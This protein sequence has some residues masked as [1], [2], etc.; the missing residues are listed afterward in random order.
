MK[1]SNGFRIIL[2]IMLGVFALDCVGAILLMH[3]WVAALVL[4]AIAFAMF[5]LW[6]RR[7][8]RQVSNEGWNLGPAV[9]L[10][11]PDNPLRIE[12]AIVSPKILNLGMLLIGGPGSGKTIASLSFLHS[13]PPDSGWLYGEGKGDIDIFKMC[14][15][16]GRKPRHF[17]STELPGS[18]SINLFAGDAKDV[19]DR[20]GMVLIGE[21]ASTSFYSDEQRMVLTRII[22]LLR[23]LPVATNLRDLYV[24]LAVEDAGNELLRRAADAGADPVSIQLARAWF[25]VPFKD[26]IKNI[27][28]L[29]NRLFIFV[30]GEQT[31]RLNAYQPDIDIP[32]AVKNNESVYLHLPLTA[33]A[34]D[35]AIAI[36]ETFG[37]VA[38][39]RQLAGTEGLRMF[40]QLFDDWGAF[41][42][43]GFG[44]Y[45]ARCRSAA[46]SLSFGF[47]SRAQLD[48]VGTTF[49]DV[50][51]DTIA[52]KFILRVQGEATADYA[53]SLLGEYESLDVGT[54]STERAD[55]GTRGSSIHALRKWRIEPR[56]LRTLLPGE[57]YVSTLENDGKKMHNPLWKLRIPMPKVDGWEDVQMPPARK[58]EEGEG[59]GFWNR[60]MNPAKLAEIHATLQTVMAAEDKAQA[61]ANA[62]AQEQAKS[63]ITNNPGFTLE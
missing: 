36:V 63:D 53:V 61:T 8:K 48:E 59:L 37:V 31:D 55:Q 4:A 20:M 46:M 13:L 49:A 26:R 35:V 23:C 41:F 51:D 3:S 18:D 34:R 50:L 30:N 58:H 54:S 2:L 56:E 15:A 14:V 44:P 60:Y 22:P 16:M 7:E 1:L 9:E 52:S 40:P 10:T 39:S 57:A 29:L 43:N 5:K 38:R 21:T 32:T 62:K 47:Q 27:S 19:I 45:S 11:N 33:F 17:F 6:P 28:G 12:Q 24:T 25:G 42:H